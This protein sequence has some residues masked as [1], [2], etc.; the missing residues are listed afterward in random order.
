[1]HLTAR[2][3]GQTESRGTAGIVEL[4]PDSD[5]RHRWD[6]GESAVSQH[7]EELW[8][9]ASGREAAPTSSAG[10][11][12]GPAGNSR[13]TG[14]LGISLLLLS[15]L[16]VVTLLDVTGLMAWHVTL[17]A[18][19]VPFAAAK[20]GSTGWRLTRYYRGSPPY[21]DAGAPPL[22][23]R[24]LGPLVVL[25]T[26]ALLASGVVLVLLGPDRGRQ[27]LVAAAGFGLAPITVHQAAFVV[28]AAVVSLHVLA[29]LVPAW[30]RTV[31][32]RRQPLSS[33][34]PARLALTASL[35]VIGAVLAVVLLPH[36]S[37][38]QQDE[39]RGGARTHRIPSTAPADVL[40]GRP[41]QPRGTAVAVT[42]E[43]AVSD[44]RVGIR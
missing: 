17:G 38:W 8:R 21:R 10:R 28:W 22:L 42:R 40:P 18:L 25:S 33:G 43:L 37:G 12:G 20:I 14:W 4:V 16:Q 2:E 6:A 32:G 5:S 30:Q 39:R 15:L 24:M 41:S 29:R 1:M 36:R 7:L 35:V 31:D 44:L 19:P 13:L 27:P 9:E 3:V 34:G 26:V 11:W 23:L